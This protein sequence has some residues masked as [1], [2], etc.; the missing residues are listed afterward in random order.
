MAGEVA[1]GAVGGEVVEG[2]EGD[3]VFVGERGKG[4]V[5]VEE[6]GG[7][8]V[9]AGA[10]GVSRMLEKGFGRLRAR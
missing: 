9:F 5:G 10:L 8:V 2:G 1:D 3:V 6:A 7:A 4:D